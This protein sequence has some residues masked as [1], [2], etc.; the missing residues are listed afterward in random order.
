MIQEP[1]VV[2]HIGAV[3]LTD[4]VFVKIF[5][6]N[7]QDP[8]VLK[9]THRRKF[10][11]QKTNKLVFCVRLHAFCNGHCAQTS[12]FFVIILDLGFGPGFEEVA[13]IGANASLV[14]RRGYP[15]NNG[16]FSFDE[17]VDGLDSTF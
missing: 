1:E 14:G 6:D 7:I 10:S 16:R 12:S 13:L 2:T 3:H 8:T 4:C 15:R 5:S 9:S 17:T 11:S